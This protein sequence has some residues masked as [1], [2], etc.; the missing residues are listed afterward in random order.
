MRRFRCGVQRKPWM[1]MKMRSLSLFPAAV[2]DLMEMTAGMRGNIASRLSGSGA[3]EGIRCICS[4]IHDA[5]VLYFFWYL[6][7]ARADT[8]KAPASQKGR[9]ENGF[10]SGTGRSVERKKT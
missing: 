4:G 8:G 9:Y 3:A 5:D 7:P 6:K 1:F 10:S 2:T